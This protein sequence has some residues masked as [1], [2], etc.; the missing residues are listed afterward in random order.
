ME[1]REGE[2]RKV[3]GQGEGRAKQSPCTKIHGEDESRLVQPRD[4]NP[5]PSKKRLWISSVCPAGWRVGVER[6][7]PGWRRRAAASQEKGTWVGRLPRG[8]L[9]TIWTH[10]VETF[11]LESR[12]KWWLWSGGGGELW[13]R[14]SSPLLRVQIL[15]TLLCRA[16]WWKE[17]KDLPLSPFVCVTLVVSFSSLSSSVFSPGK[18]RPYLIPVLGG[19]ESSLCSPGSE[20]LNLKHGSEPPIRLTKDCWAPWPVFD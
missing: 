5:S 12:T 3:V 11:G 1:G 7:C 18:C 17:A 2:G 4:L 14:Y 19:I 20:V 13:D 15:V 6:P 10:Q 16:V 9:R 8:A